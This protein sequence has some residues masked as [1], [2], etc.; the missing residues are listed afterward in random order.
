[1]KNYRPFTL[2]KQSTPKVSQF[3][4]K[5]SKGQVVDVS[6]SVHRSESNK[7]D[8]VEKLEASVEQ[9]IEETEEIFE[10]DDED[11][12]IDDDVFN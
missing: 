8:P 11:S 5:D 9:S 1:M 12:Q 6:L 2:T 4:L 7:L 3:G 10:K